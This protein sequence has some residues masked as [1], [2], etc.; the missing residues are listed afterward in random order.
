MNIS[1]NQNF[2][3]CFTSKINAQSSIINDISVS[4]AFG[5][6]V[7]NR[8][9]ARNNRPF[10][11][12]F[13]DLFDF[14]FRKRT[15]WFDHTRSKLVVNDLLKIWDICRGLCPFEGQ[16]FFLWPD[17][18]NYPLPRWTQPLAIDNQNPTG[19]RP[20]RQRS[21]VRSTFLCVL[22]IGWRCFVPCLLGKNLFA[23]LEGFEF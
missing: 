8:L 13:H 23:S 11:T 17:N 10:G 3:S 14:S 15:F 20:R 18:F 1:L 7:I 22:K 9:E 12:M 5:R 19:L 6:N 21:K 16:I 2:N 4:K